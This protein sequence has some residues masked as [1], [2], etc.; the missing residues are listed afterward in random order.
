MEVRRMP[1]SMSEL[2]HHGIKGQEWGDRNGP[3]YPLDSNASVQ[4][5]KKKKSLV[6]RIKNKRKGKQ[7]QKAKAAKKAER[8]EKA[9]IINSG[10]AEEVK[11][12]SSKLTNDELDAAIKKIELNAKLNTY[13]G[14]GKNVT[15]AKT[16]ADYVE[17][18]DK[19]F[20]MVGSAADGISKAYDLYKKLNG[21]NT[22]SKKK[23][24]DNDNAKTLKISLEDN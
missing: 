4:A 20:K 1:N 18:I 12:I 19:T 13:T 7:L 8:E 5:K 3:P 11:K 21:V 2:Y 9:R 17:Q 16:G 15:R 10:N 23:K 24:K 6:T 14:N 22:G